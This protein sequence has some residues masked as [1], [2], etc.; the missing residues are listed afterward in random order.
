MMLYSSIIIIFRRFFHV[1]SDALLNSTFALSLSLSV[2]NYLQCFLIII[3]GSV[4]RNSPRNMY[5]FKLVVTR[6][7]G[8]RRR[9]EESGRKANLENEEKQQQQNNRNDLKCY[10]DIFFFGA[11]G[12]RGGAGWYFEILLKQAS[13]RYINI[14]PRVDRFPYSYQIDNS[15]LE[16]PTEMEFFLLLRRNRSLEESIVDQIHICII[17][18][19]RLP[20]LLLFFPIH[21]SCVSHFTAVYILSPL[22]LRLFLSLHSLTPS[23]FLTLW[24]SASCSCSGR[25][26]MKNSLLSHS[27]RRRRTRYLSVDIL[28]NF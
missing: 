5:I 9:R 11:E 6:M 28:L 15:F 8:A 4:R 18:T 7:R 23:L 27:L 14:S 26:I 13:F 1:F 22:S 25:I 3:L 17:Q 20:L 24:H 21:P 10:F 2:R 19:N 16:L 12:C